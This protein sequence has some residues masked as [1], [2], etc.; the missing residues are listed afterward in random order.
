MAR[1]R[2]VYI[3]VLCALMLFCASRLAWASEYHG[4]ITFGGFPVPGATVTATQGS[5][6]VSVVSDAGGVYSF[7]DLADGPWKIEIEMQ[8]F[9]KVEAEVTVAKNMAPGKWELTLLPMDQLMAQSK[10]TQAPPTLPETADAVSTS[11]VREGAPE[12]AAAGPDR[13]D[14]QGAG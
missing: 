7:D 14:S 11:Q 5:K 9:A 3:S 13:R 4:Q 12:R 2:C 10:L 6:T 8:C 1:V